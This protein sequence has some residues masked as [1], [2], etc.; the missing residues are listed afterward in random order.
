MQPRRRSSYPEPA[1]DWMVPAPGSRVLDVGSGNGAFAAMIDRAG[2]RVCCVDSNPDRVRRIAARLPTGLHTVAQAESLPFASESFDV[3][4]VGESVTRFAPG[5]ALA[6][7]ARVLRPGGHLAVVFNTRDD[8]VPWVKRLA[9]LLQS[10]DPT[11]MRGDYGTETVAALD[12]SP[13]FPEVEEKSFRNWMPID[14]DG[15]LQMVR[16]RPALAGLQTERL[17]ELLDQVGALYDASAR[18][19]EP[20]LLPFQATCRRAL[21]D[22]TELTMPV[23]EDGLR[24]SMRF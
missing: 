21:V 16:S 18:P 5:L 14:R 13:Y 9:R 15:L 11:A 4:T 2:H 1:I 7:F 8:T 3:V 6:E 22:H 23:S 20:L 17:A 24:I 12:E 19:P 10:E